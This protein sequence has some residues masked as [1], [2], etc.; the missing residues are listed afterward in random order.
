[1][2]PPLFT[3]ISFLLSFPIEDIFSSYHPLK[4]ERSSNCPSILRK[5]TVSDLSEG[6]LVISSIVIRSFSRIHLSI[7]FR[8]LPTLLPSDGR[9]YLTHSAIAPYTLCSA[10]A[11]YISAL[12][13]SPIY[14]VINDN[15]ISISAGSAISG[16][17]LRYNPI[18]MC[19]SFSFS[20]LSFFSFLFLSSFTQSY[21]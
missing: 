4:N 5:E 3:Y 18:G 9:G 19:V 20:I 8:S 15:N 13:N 21:Q 11:P 17:N 10:I 1:M 16:T 14:L 12:C 7:P 2:F 6:C